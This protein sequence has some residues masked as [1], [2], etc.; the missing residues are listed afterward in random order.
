AAGPVKTGPDMA[1]FVVA[2]LRNDPL[3]TKLSDEEF[4]SFRDGLREFLL[5]IARVMIQQEKNKM[6]KKPPTECLIAMF[7]R[8]WIHDHEAP[9]NQQF[10]NTCYWDCTW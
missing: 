4:E 3:D 1:S 6:K 2:T 10:C 9:S 5:P 7:A 8:Y